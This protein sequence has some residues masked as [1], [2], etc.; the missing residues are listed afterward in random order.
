MT[1]LTSVQF[2]GFES[3]IAYMKTPQGLQGPWSTMITLNNKI[4]PDL[5]YFQSLPASPDRPQERGFAIINGDNGK[6]LLA[7][8]TSVFQLR[9]GAEIP[10]SLMQAQLYKE[11]VESAPL[12]QIEKQ[13]ALE[14]A[15]NT[16]DYIRERLPV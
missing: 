15:N 8:A 13:I 7:P 3:P 14:A 5:D 16:I 12:S 9:T 2:K 6:R 10:I 4:K 11:L 1:K